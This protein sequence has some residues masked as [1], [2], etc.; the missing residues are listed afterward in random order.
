M[1]LSFITEWIQFYEKHKAMF[2]DNFYKNIA[3]IPAEHAFI[4]HSRTGYIFFFYNGCYSMHYTACF[5]YPHVILN[6]PSC[7]VPKDRTKPR[8]AIKCITKKFNSIK[9]LYNTMINCQNQVDKQTI[10]KTVQY[11]PYNG[12][13]SDPLY[14]NF[15]HIKTII[16]P[17]KQISLLEAETVQKNL[18]P[19]EIIICSII[20]TLYDDGKI[21]HIIMHDKIYTLSINS[22]MSWHGHI[23][24]PFTFKDK[25]L[26]NPFV[27]TRGSRFCTWFTKKI[28]TTG[29]SDSLSD[30]NL[31][32]SSLSVS[33][34]S[35]LLKSLCN[36]LFI[37][38][39]ESDKQK[40]NTWARLRHQPLSKTTL[41]ELEC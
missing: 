28:H 10:N 12:G 31:F 37:S 35:S 16:G 8:P 18:K 38:S 23:I 20:Q 40:P 24:K 15:K 9:K 17:Y 2:S 36:R 11:K 1:K 25:T 13:K 7:I 29:R 32:D 33:S 19:H 27:E 26:I 21:F 6:G 5:K 41:E 34:D 4:T 3:S 14:D 30:S 39:K 22:I